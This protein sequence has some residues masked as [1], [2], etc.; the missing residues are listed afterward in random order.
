MGIGRRWKIATI[1]GIP[2]YLGMSWI[3]VAILYVWLQYVRLTENWNAAPSTAAWLAVFAA[4][5]FFGSVLHHEGAHAVMARSLGLPVLGV[6]LVFWGG[7]TETKAHL[8][9]A[10]GEFLVAVVGPH[11]TQAGAGRQFV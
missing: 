5:V 3:W 1:R 7:A 11:N 8:K 6:T 9:G 2:L 4:A 10:R